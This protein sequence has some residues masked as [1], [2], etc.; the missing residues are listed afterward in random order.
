MKCTECGTKCVLVE[1]TDRSRQYECPSCCNFF[2]KPIPIKARR[3]P[4][5]SRTF[6]IVLSEH[7]SKTRRSGA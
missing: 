6:G 3:I 5:D 2:E 7:V 1:T 4:L